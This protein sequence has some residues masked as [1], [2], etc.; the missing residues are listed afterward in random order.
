MIIENLKLKE[1]VVAVI[2]RKDGKKRIFRAKNIVG[3]EGDKYYAQRACGETPTNNFANCRL[4][5]GSAAAAKDDDYSDFTPIEGTEKA[6]SAGY[7]KTDDDDADNTG[8]GVDVITWK[9]EWT[10]ADF[11]ASGI[12][13]GII[14]IPSASGTDPLLTRW[15]WADAFSK[16]ADTTLKLFVNHTANGV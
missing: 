5:S 4:G 6:K 1:N 14:T 2:T 9:F 12:R 16:D 7:P 10:G 15:V 11:N 13:E 3:N 8:A